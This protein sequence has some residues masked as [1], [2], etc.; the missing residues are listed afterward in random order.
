MILFIDYRLVLDAIY[1]FI[2]L[3]NAI[4]VIFKMAFQFE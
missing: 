4:N 1:I 3:K 2:Y